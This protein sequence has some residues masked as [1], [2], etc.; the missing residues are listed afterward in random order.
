MDSVAIL[1]AIALFLS[2]K[3]SEAAFTPF[4][5]LW[6]PTSEWGSIHYHHRRAEFDEKT[7]HNCGDGSS[8]NHYWSNRIDTKNDAQHLATLSLSEDNTRRHMLTAVAAT[9]II[10]SL[11]GLPTSPVHAIQSELSSSTSLMSSYNRTQQ[12]TERITVPLTYNGQEFFIYYRVDGS[13]FRAIIDTGSPFLLIPGTCGTNTRYKSGCYKN[14]GISL[15]NSGFP[16]TYEIFDGFE[17]EVEWRSAPFWFVNATGSLIGP[18]RIIFGVASESILSGTGGVFFGLLRD[19]DTWIR[20]SF[21]SQ[22]N[23]RSIQLNLVTNKLDASGPNTIKSIK[24]NN[25]VE[26]TPTLTLST[27]PMIDPTNQNYIP[28]INDLRRKYGD[29]VNH[30]TARAE[31]MQVNGYPLVV[32]TK[33]KPIYVIFDTGVSGT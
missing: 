3:V 33:R 5:S 6:S 27:G 18:P 29:P 15:A 12:Y 9:T 7:T 8:D 21:L 11:L 24:G 2:L 30:Y 26:A 16:P 19:T 28:L 23:V 17:G 20:P 14:Q 25:V 22:T 1:A 31:E 32:G 13:L 4:P 10:S